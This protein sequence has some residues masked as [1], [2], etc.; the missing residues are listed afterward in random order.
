MRYVD[1]I[2]ADEAGRPVVDLSKISLIE[3]D[4]ELA[5]PGYVPDWARWRR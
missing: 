1:A 2:M 3:A 5:P 4:R